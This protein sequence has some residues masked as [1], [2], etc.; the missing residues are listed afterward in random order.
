MMMPAIETRALMR[1]FGK[2][3]AVD[4]VSMTVPDKAVYGYPSEH[5]PA[6]EA[7]LGEPLGDAP[8]G[9]NLST[10]GTSQVIG[11]DGRTIDALPEGEPGAMVTDVPLRTGMTPDVVLTDAETALEALGEL[12][13][14]HIRDDLIQ[15]IFSRF[16]VGK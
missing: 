7:E 15:T 9:E 14:K 12:N 4:A 3:T 16:C 13:G 8:F 11:P 6:W 10:V 2:R 5:L 1:R